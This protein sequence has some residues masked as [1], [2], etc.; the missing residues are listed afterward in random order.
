MH[1]THLFLP[2]H[3]HLSLALKE[4]KTLDIGQQAAAKVV[5]HDGHGQNAHCGLVVDGQ[6]GLAEAE[7][8]GRQ[9]LEQLVQ[10]LLFRKASAGEERNDNPAFWNLGYCCKLQQSPIIFADKLCHRLP[11]VKT[12]WLAI[13]NI[14]SMQL[15]SVLLFWCEL[16]PTKDK[17]NRVVRSDN[18]ADPGCLS[19]IPDPNLFYPGSRA[20]KIFG[21]R[22]RVRIKEFEYFNHKVNK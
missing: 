17:I 12:S 15:S 9:E 6:M 7:G 13:R 5:F 21:S 10:G 14:S 2:Q 3:G 19:R 20:K 18:V 11:M 8:D 16:I 1:I 4:L 22:I